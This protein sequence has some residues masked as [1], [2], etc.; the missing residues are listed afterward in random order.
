[1]IFFRP[2]RPPET[3]QEA[4]WRP[5]K[6]KFRPGS[7]PGSILSPQGLNLEPPGLDFGASGTSFSSPRASIFD[8]P[9]VDFGR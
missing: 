7:L 3:L 9:R 8:P 5:S 2:R 1:M 4:F 6:T